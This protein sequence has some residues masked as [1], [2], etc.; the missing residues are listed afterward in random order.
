MQTPCKN[1]R[2]D[3]SEVLRASVIQDA[4]TVVLA[5]VARGSSAHSVDMARGR[6]CVRRL[7]GGF[8]LD[9]LKPSVLAVLG[10]RCVEPILRSPSRPRDLADARGQ[11]QSGF[12]SIARRW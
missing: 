9:D 1:A 6:P 12:D 5:A 7:G 10:G 11:Q 2:S 4:I 3:P 8:L